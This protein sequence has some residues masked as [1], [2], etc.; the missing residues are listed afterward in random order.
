MHV[1]AQ[2]KITEFHDP[3][4]QHIS[5]SFL[6][7]EAAPPVSLLESTRYAG[8]S[9]DARATRL[10]V[11]M[12]SIR[13]SKHCKAEK[14]SNQPTRSGDGQKNKARTSGSVI[15]FW[16]NIPQDDDVHMVPIKVRRKLVYDMDLL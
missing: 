9:R 4:Y 12:S 6:D 3:L 10:S 13:L 1:H 15:Q 2:Q 14:K 8:R 7:Y 16:A 5:T 11:S